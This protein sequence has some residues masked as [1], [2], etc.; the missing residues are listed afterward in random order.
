MNLSERNISAKAIMAILI[1]VILSFITGYI[2]FSD[3]CAGIRGKIKAY[4]GDPEEQYRL[5]VMYSMGIGVPKD[6]VRALKWLSGAGLAGHASSAYL[7]ALMYTEG[8]GTDVDHGKAVKWYRM[9]AEKN[10][11]PAQAALGRIYTEGIGVDKNTQEGIKWKETA[12]KQGNA[13]AIYDMGLMYYKGEFVERDE[14]EAIRW[15]TAGAKIG[16]RGSQYYLGLIKFR[17]GYID[18]AVSLISK[19]ADKNYPEA[20]L[21]LGVIYLTGQG[22]VKQDPAKGYTLFTKAAK[23]GVAEAAYFVGMMG[24]L[25]IGTEQNTKTAFSFIEKAAKTGHREALYIKGVMLRDGTACTADI[26]K[27]AEAFM[28]AAEMDLPEAMREYGRYLY[29]RAENGSAVQKAFEQIERAAKKLDPDSFILMGRIADEGRHPSKKNKSSAEY[30]RNASLLGSANASFILGQKYELGDGV[31]QDLGEAVFFYTRAIA[32]ASGDRG[33]IIP[34]SMSPLNRTT[35]IQYPVWSFN[36]AP[37]R[38]Y[39]AMA[40]Y[41]LGMMCF[42]GRGMPVDRKRGM[43]LI[44]SAA[45]RGN[46]EAVNM[47]SSQE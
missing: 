38:R 40:E 11:A 12:A 8:R 35:G 29:E 34:S 3:S 16:D 18:E 6:P 7:A 2:F 25:G 17:D 47:I 9:A 22:G 45:S 36:E 14:G 15:F 5:G 13:S 43:E 4:A 10:F 42:W 41:S 33:V 46:P 24:L 21:D 31:K 20:L 32:Q 28:A 30:Y 37:G 1:L 39:G 44:R 23:S 19:A 27:A 26:N